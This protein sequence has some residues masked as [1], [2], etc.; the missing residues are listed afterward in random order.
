MAHMHPTQIIKKP[1]V[2]EKSTWESQHLIPK[3]P[4]VGE[5]ANRYSFEVD[6]K[7]NKKQIRAA[8]EGLFKVRVQR[9][10]TQIRKGQYRRTRFGVAQT[11]SWKKAVV[12]V[13]PEDRIDLF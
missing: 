7:A 6:L 3:G 13:H 8:I 9:V 4:R 1:L 12:Q 10:S 2:T 5:P 11:S